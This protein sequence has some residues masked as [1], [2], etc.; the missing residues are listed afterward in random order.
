MGPTIT[1]MLVWFLF[2]FQP[3]HLIAL[4]ESQFSLLF[5]SPSPLHFPPPYREKNL[6]APKPRNPIFHFP[7]NRIPKSPCFFIQFVSTSENSLQIFVV[8]VFL[9]FRGD[10]QLFESFARLKIMVSKR[11]GFRRPNYFMGLSN[12]G[13]SQGSSPRQS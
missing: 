2:C 4:L 6:L 9:G 8:V 7:P 10:G 5:L 13:A 12:A 3:S 1:H 11:G